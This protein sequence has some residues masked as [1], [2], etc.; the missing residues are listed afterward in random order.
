MV[1]DVETHFS[2]V[3]TLSSDGPVGGL[4]VVESVDLPH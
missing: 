1:G 3:Y 2:G 4:T